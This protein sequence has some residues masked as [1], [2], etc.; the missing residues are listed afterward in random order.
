MNFQELVEKIADGDY[1][2][3]QFTRERMDINLIASVPYPGFY[4]NP[5]YLIFIAKINKYQN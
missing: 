1:P 4:S 3:I 5:I 2:G